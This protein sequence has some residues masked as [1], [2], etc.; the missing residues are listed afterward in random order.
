MNYKYL[1]FDADETLLDFKMAERMALSA[2]LKYFN[3]PENEESHDVYSKANAEQWTLLEK[4]LV[5]KEELKSNRFKKFCDTFGYN[6]DPKEM[7]DIYISSL[8]DQS[9]LIDG[10]YDIIK[11]LSTKFELYIITNG[12]KYSQTKRIKNSPIYTY[13]KGIFISE[14]MGF[15][16]PDKR[17]FE[18]AVKNIEGFN[19]KEAIIIGDS[20]SSDILGGMNF[21][22]DT[23]WYNP[24]NKSLPTNFKPTYI[25]SQLEQIK[26]IL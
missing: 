14:E 9:Y 24:Q 21:G 2:T 4:N 7:S 17:F 19:K 18:S 22:I 13:F 11:E 1:L 20:L 5:T 10:A 12:F 23:C 8:A 25:I 3:L 6:C 26:N 16:K 15:E